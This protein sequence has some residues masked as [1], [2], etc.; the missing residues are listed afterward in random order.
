MQRLGTLRLGVALAA[1]VLADAGVALAQDTAAAPDAA[2]SG[3]IVVTATRKSESL[4]RVPLSITALTQ[5]EIQK[6]GIRNVDDIVRL[7]PGSRSARAVQRSA[8]SR[9]AASP[10][11]RVPPLSVSISMIRRSRC[12]RWA[13]HPRSCIRRFSILNVSKCCAVPGHAVRGRVGRRH[14]PLYPARAQR[15]QMERPCPYGNRHHHQWR[16]QL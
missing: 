3:E 2:P 5:Q 1:M 11:R 6:Q 12:A 9:S 14:D 8:M 10:R 16:G 4:S 15:G 7:T 13:W